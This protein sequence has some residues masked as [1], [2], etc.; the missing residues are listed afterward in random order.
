[1]EETK[2][3]VNEELEFYDDEHIDDILEM[4]GVD[5]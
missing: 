2:P 1:M 4:E 5:D 3:V